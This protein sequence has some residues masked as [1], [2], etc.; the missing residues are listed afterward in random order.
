MPAR[1]VAN[2]WPCPMIARR[3]RRR[4]PKSA[5]PHPPQRLLGA[6]EWRWRGAGSAP[7]KVLTRPPPNCT[8]KRA[9][10]CR[11]PPPSPPPL[12]LPPRPS[13]PAPLALFTCAQRHAMAVPN[14][15]PL[16]V[17]NQVLLNQRSR[18]F[19]ADGGGA[20]AVGV[21]LGLSPKRRMSCSF[22]L[23]AGFLRSVRLCSAACC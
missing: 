16:W 4:A 1:T 13:A 12:R 23:S 21:G 7:K 15:L 9:K 22:K 17:S 2:L 3:M 8:A 11:R 5:S 20:V 19:V 10:F 6:C 14:A 18:L